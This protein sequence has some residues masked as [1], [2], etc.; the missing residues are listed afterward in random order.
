MTLLP[1]SLRPPVLWRNGKG[2]TTEIVRRETSGAEWRMSIATIADDSSFSSFAGHTRR[3]MPLASAGLTL[4]TDG[5][6]EAIAQY[7]TH[8]FEGECEVAATG[9]R[10]PGKDLNLIFQRSSLDGELVH[11]RIRNET[12]V[13]AGDGET[14]VVVCLAG[15]LSW[16]D[17]S[18]RLHDAVLLEAGE[19]ALLS[20]TADVAVARVRR[21]ATRQP[22]AQ[23]GQS[24][25][26]QLPTVI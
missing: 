3:L 13:R 6:E 19:H 9:V 5:V 16:A 18:L 12:V 21:L 17:G 14:V 22:A 4:V 11:Q 23:P 26:A 2:I 25:S 24:Q 15:E 7:A 8:S 20:G 1:A 10:E